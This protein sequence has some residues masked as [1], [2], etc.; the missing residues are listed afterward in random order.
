MALDSAQKRGSV[1]ALSLPG[2]SWTAVPTGALNLATERLG[3]MYYATSIFP[4]GS[5]PGLPILPSFQGLL[6]N[7]GK[8]IR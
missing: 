6:R 4:S 3:I 2:R 8:M 1:I 5:G 7:V